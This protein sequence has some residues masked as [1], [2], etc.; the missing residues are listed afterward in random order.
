MPRLSVVVGPLATT[1]S[2]MSPFPWLLEQVPAGE[3][4]LADRYYCT[5]WLV[6][7]AQAR[8]GDVVFRMHH[9]RDYD[10][11]RGQRLGADDHV[12]TWHRPQRPDW[13]DEATYA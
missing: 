4:L 13:M 10:F 5:Y 7:M 1:K 11:R 9:L 8:G 12:V 2:T 3:V 6:A